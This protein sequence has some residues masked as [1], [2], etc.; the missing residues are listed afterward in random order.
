MLARF[1]PADASGEQIEAAKRAVDLDRRSALA[2]DLWAELLTHVERF[3]E[4]LGVCQQGEASCTAETF[5][6]AGRRAWIEA[7]RGR[8]TDA[9]TLMREVLAANRSYLWGWSQLVAWLT[10]AELFVEAEAAL[11][12]MRQIWPHDASVHR[13]LALLLLKRKESGA[14][15]AAFAKA[16]ELAPADINAAH[17][18]LQLQLQS[19]DL[20]GAMA[21]LQTMQLHQPGTYTLAAEIDLRLAQDDLAAASKCLES[22]IDSP[23]PDPWPLESAVDAFQ[24][25]CRYERAQRILASAVRRGD[26]NPQSAA[27]LIRLYVASHFFFRAVRVFMKLP[28]G[29]QQRRAA[30]PL[31]QLLA[32]NDRKLLFRWVLHRKAEVLKGDDAAWGQVG[33]GLTR[34]DMLPRVA[35]W[36][37]DWRERK[38]VQPWM[39]FNYCL[40]L[41]DVGRYL[42]STEIARH[43]IDCWAH[44][45]GSSDMHLYLAVEAAL[46]G[47]VGDARQHLERATARE[48]V[49]YDQ[50]LLA[51]A[52][53]LADFHEAPRELRRRDFHKIRARLSPQFSGRR[54]RRAM[55]DARRTFM[56]AADVFAR[57][58]AGPAAWI[59]SRWKLHERWYLVIASLAGFWLL[60]LS[61]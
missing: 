57:E 28:S 14:A 59:W 38:V 36:L 53:A 11:E 6:L 25:H 15:Q 19:S 17:N 7:Q 45:D 54:F 30:A 23:D 41:R 48:T 55:R 21:T 29:E 43:V 16:F 50:Q 20:A 61:G 60:Y 51:L 40:G 13:Q 56:R 18:L 46:A 3:E 9:I 34:F 10:R 35:E 31:M 37:A 22:L 52:H 49:A 26:T 27:A 44:R 24:K 47:A 2:W 58:G 32:E 1:L 33:Y 42:E 12:T 5:I 39:L 8:A 4:A